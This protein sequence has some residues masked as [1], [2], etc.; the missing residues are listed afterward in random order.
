VEFYRETDTREVLKKS[1]LFEGMEFYIVNVNDKDP[2]ANKPYLEMRIVEN[3][4]RR[5]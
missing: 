5:V 4:G 3:G 1:T 2:V